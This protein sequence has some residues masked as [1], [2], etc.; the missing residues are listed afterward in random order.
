MHDR[1]LRRYGKFLYYFINLLSSSASTDDFEFQLRWVE[2]SGR[3][4]GRAE[5][6]TIKIGDFAIG[7][8]ILVIQVPDGGTLRGLA[9]DGGA[10]GSVSF[11][12]GDGPLKR[13]QVTTIRES[14]ISAA[15]V[16]FAVAELSYDAVVVE[17]AELLFGDVVDTLDGLQTLII[18]PRTDYSLGASSH[19][20]NRWGDA[21]KVASSSQ[22]AGIARFKYKIQSLLLWFRKH[23]RVDYGVYEPRYLTCAL[24]KGNDSDAILVSE[25]LFHIG[26]LS[27]D[28]RLIVMNQKVL[29][30]H[31]IHYKQQNTLMFGPET[32]TLYQRFLQWPRAADWEERNRD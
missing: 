1:D 26:A 30:T 32:N 23:G 22:S 31:G 25:F 28:G 11:A 17:A 16:E 15:T 13:G 29:A 2:Q 6:D 7:D 27:R 4:I 3:W 9:I 12:R 20:K 14:S 18:R 8:D 10:A 19:V 5:S 24:N 21:L